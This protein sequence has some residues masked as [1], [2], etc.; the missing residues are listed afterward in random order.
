MSQ[1]QVNVKDAQ[2]L[3]RHNRASTPQDLYQQGVPEVCRLLKRV[4]RDGNRT[5]EA[6]PFFRAAFILG[7]PEERERD[8]GMIPNGIPG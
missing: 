8:S 4:A 7:N 3:M 1:A 6:S 5:A 2:G